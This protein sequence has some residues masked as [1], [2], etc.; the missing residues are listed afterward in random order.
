MFDAKKLADLPNLSTEQVKQLESDIQQEFETISKQYL[1]ARLSRINYMINNLGDRIEDI[2]TNG[3]QW[4]EL[5][6]F[7]AQAVENIKYNREQ[8]CLN[9]K[10]TVKD[11]H[12][13]FREIIKNCPN[14]LDFAPPLD[15]PFKDQ[16]A[17][18]IKNGIKDLSGVVNEKKYLLD[19]LEKNV[20]RQKNIIW[21]N[22]RK[23]IINYKYHLIN[24]KLLRLSTLYKAHQKLD[25]NGKYIRRWENYH[26]PLVSKNPKPDG[27]DP[28]NFISNKVNKSNRIETTNIKN[29]YLSRYYAFKA[30]QIKS[31]TNGPLGSTTALSNCKGLTDTEIDNDLALMKTGLSSSTSHP[32]QSIDLD[33]ESEQEDLVE[34]QEEK[35]EVP[36]PVTPQNQDNSFQQQYA[37]LMAVPMINETFTIPD[38]PSIEHFPLQ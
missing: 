27:L 24:K 34:E 14:P 13:E 17:P 21:Q 36:D 22:Y 11:Y 37:K 35:N 10:A 30:N 16:F 3:Q 9:E 19:S 6:T 5:F 25:T 28:L 38:L 26:R 8:V 7:E 32:E 33:Q 12:H 29:E 20:E 31:E 15:L 18:L 4:N 23:E 2:Q 1:Q